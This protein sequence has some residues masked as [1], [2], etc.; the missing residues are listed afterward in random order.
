MVEIW[1]PVKHYE[2]LYEISNLGRVKSV[3]R[4]R[5]GVNGKPV[6]VNERIVRQH[7]NSCGYMLVGLSK[8]G[9]QKQYLV[10]RLVAEMFIPNPN[11]YLEINHIDENKTN[12]CSRNIEWCSR[13]YNKHYNKN[14]LKAGTKLKKA[15]LQYSLD[16]IYITE[17]DSVKQAIRQTG[18]SHI[19]EC[20]NFKLSSSGGYIWRFK[21]G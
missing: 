19:S 6:L 11:N 12:N 14:A 17:Y 10:H 21:D 1:L 18:I 8:S 9:V 3:K 4:Y 16:G 2:G 20:C 15:V 5:S 13:S 7:K